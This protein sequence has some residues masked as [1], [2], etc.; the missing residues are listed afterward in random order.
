MTP[1]QKLSEAIAMHKLAKANIEN[2]DLYEVLMHRTATLKMQHAQMIGEAAV[3]IIKENYGKWL[4][5]K[6]LEAKAFSM[7]IADRFGINT[8]VVITDD[9]VIMNL[10]THQS[11]STLLKAFRRH[12]PIMKANTHNSFSMFVPT[13]LKQLVI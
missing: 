7:A 1:A 3:K 6:Q 2:Y 8:E 9:G 12:Q 10:E 11:A 13:Q 5:D 4:N